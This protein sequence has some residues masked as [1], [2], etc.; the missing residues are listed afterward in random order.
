MNGLMP[1]TQT[2]LT[3]GL[4]PGSHAWPTNGLL[5]R[6]NLQFENEA[7]SGPLCSGV[8]PGEES[9]AKSVALNSSA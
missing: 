4:V 6:V 2:W 1:G 8:N 9:T 5:P 7:G 3:N